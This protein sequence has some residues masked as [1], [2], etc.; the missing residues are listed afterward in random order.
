MVGDPKECRKHALRSGDLAHAAKTR[1]LDTFVRNDIEKWRNVIERRQGPG[2][3]TPFEPPCR[4]C[5]IA[6]SRRIESLR[7]SW[8][9][10]RITPRGS[11]G[12]SSRAS[13]E[14][15][16]ID[17]S[18]AGRGADPRID[19]FARDFD[20]IVGVEHATTKYRS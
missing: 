15:Q 10:I 4:S 7:Q 14:S 11:D 18:C 12:G 3:L 17:S 8:R 1:E 16:R 5:S 19:H 9:A 6:L 2:R 20:G 13:G